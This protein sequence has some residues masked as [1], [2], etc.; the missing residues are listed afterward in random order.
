MAL[1]QRSVRIGVELTLDQLREVNRRAG[2]DGI[3]GK[4][5]GTYIAGVLFG[6]PDAL[7]LDR[8]RRVRDSERARLRAEIEAERA[9]RSTAV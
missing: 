3:D 1:T 9:Q 6:E 7:L 8:V 5:R 2:I 4:A